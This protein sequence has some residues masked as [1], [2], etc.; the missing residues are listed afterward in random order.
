[1]YAGVITQTST[2][3]KWALFEWVEF[4]NDG[5]VE[6][7]QLWIGLNG[8]DDIAYAYDPTLAPTAAHGIPALIGIEN[9]EGN[10][11]TQITGYHGTDYRA[12]SAPAIAGGS[13][14]LTYTVG[15]TAAGP[16]AAA[17]TFT[18]SSLPGSLAASFPITVTP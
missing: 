12:V 18:S 11:G 3:K 14:S 5:Q 8:V 17:A 9:D 2:G 6:R 1:M 10:R 15:G 4:N 13:A 16:G 7:F